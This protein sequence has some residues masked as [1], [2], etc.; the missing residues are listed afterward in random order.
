MQLEERYGKGLPAERT[1][2]RW[3]AKA[4][5]YAL[6]TRFNQVPSTF[7]Q[8]VHD[9]WQIDAKEQLHL[10]DGTRACYLTIADQKSGCLLSSFV[11]PPLSY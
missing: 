7:V 4:G 1:M 5:L 3:F 11:F 2:Q 9:L 8:R 10:S 6:K